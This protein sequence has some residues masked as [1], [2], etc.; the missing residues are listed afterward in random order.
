M[1]F[2]R[3][4]LAYLSQQFQDDE[5]YLDINSVVQLAFN[6]SNLSYNVSQAKNQRNNRIHKN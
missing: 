2:A 4:I 1:S 5:E 6:R 3:I